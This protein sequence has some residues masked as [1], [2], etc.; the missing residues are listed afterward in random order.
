MRSAERQGDTMG[1]ASGVGLPRVSFVGSR[2][3]GGSGEVLDLIIGKIGRGSHPIGNS[4]GRE[5]RRVCRV[6]EDTPPRAR[7]RGNRADATARVGETFQAEVSCPGHSRACSRSLLPLRHPEGIP[8]DADHIRFRYRDSVSSSNHS[9][10]STSDFFNRINRFLNDL[11]I[12]WPASSW[13]AGVHI[14][15]MGNLIPAINDEC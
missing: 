4:G 14:G 3:T 13:R 7:E 1:G 15:L 12:Y 8:A 11:F 9:I 10:N 5:S 6:R 2:R